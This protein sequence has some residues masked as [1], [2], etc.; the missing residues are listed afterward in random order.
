LSRADQAGDGSAPGAR[1]ALAEP[2]GAYR[3]PLSAFIRQRG[4]DPESA[5]DLVHG[6]F[7]GMVEKDSVVTIDRTKGRFRSFLVAACIHYLANCHD[8]ERTLTR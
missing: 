5:E 3:Y 6:L 7:G 2:C 8:H 4:H 1:A